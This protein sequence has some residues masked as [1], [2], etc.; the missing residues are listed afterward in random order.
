MHTVPLALHSTFYPVIAEDPI[1]RDN[2]I[3]TIK[4][5]AEGLLEEIKTILGWVVNFRSFE[6]YLPMHKLKEWLFDI[7]SAIKHSSLHVTVLESIIGRLNHTDYVFSYEIYFLNRLRIRLKKAG[8]RKYKKV[9]LEKF[10][11]NTTI[12]GIDIDHITFIFPTMTCYSDAC[13]TAI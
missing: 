9:N 11:F 3:N 7:E 5:P 12:N 6:V 4:H 2:V 8:R 13:E 10:I 1:Q